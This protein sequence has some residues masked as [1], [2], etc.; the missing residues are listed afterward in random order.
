MH[1]KLYDKAILPVWECPELTRC[2][3]ILTFC[4]EIFVFPFL[5]SLYRVV[6]SSQAEAILYSDPNLD[7]EYLPIKGIPTYTAAS[8]K[9]ILGAD[10]TALQDGRVSLRFLGIPAVAA[11]LITRA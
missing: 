4:I 8:A 5:T 9:L 6:S 3:T 7:H 1:K 11:G 10:S 2:D